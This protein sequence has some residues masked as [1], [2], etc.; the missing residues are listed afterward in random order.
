MIVRRVSPFLDLSDIHGLFVFSTVVLHS[1]GVFWVRSRATSQGVFIDALAVD[2]VAARKRKARMVRAGLVLLLLRS[3]PDH[4]LV[5]L[6]K[7][8]HRSGVDGQ[9]RRLVEL[10]FLINQ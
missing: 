8:E 10:L 4:D 5:V 3:S 1:D 9:G 2:H 7:V 6:V